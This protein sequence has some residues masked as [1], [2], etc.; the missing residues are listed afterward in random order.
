MW[1]IGK[2]ALVDVE[3]EC[4]VMLFVDFEL[5]LEVVMM[6]IIV[7]MMEY[8]RDELGSYALI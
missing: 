1:E 5:V 6:M 4:D 7:H 8:A 3:C 2:D